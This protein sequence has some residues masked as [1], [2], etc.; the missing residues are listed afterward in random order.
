M[1]VGP[2]GT[3]MSCTPGQERTS[4][5]TEGWQVECADGQGWS[6]SSGDQAIPGDRDD[7]CLGGAGSEV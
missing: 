5:R 3:V 2:E 4:R 7:S 6:I 1:A